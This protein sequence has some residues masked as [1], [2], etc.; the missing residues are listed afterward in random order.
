MPIRPENKH[1]YPKNWKEI[2]KDILKRANNC[3][4]FCGMPNKS[5]L[6]YRDKKIHSII[7][8]TDFI[9]DLHKNNL[10]AKTWL[11]CENRQ[12]VRYRLALVVLTI[13][14]IDQDPTNNDYS[15]LRALCQKCHNTLDAPFRAKH[16]KENR[17]KR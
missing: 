11:G 13:A 8:P 1:L 7:K 15:N 2:R 14:H 5:L 6:M 16:R 3:C 9:Y 17:S 12:L 4:E 10:C